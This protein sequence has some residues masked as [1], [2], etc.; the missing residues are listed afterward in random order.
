MAK[1]FANH[2]PVVLLAC[3][4]LAIWVGAAVRLVGAIFFVSERKRV[5][6]HPFLHG[7]WFFVALLLIVSVFLALP[8]TPRQARRSQSQAMLAALAGTIQLGEHF[9]SVSSGQACRLSTA[10]QLGGAVSLSRI[11]CHH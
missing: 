1:V 10:W 3:V 6:A 7:L 4:L 9:K 5:I 11:C 2:F 8:S